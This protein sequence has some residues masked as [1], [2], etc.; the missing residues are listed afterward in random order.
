MNANPQVLKALAVT[1]QI[2]GKELSAEA[3]EV[4]ALDLAEFPSDPVL[5]S[6]GRCRRELR[7]FPT[8]ADIVARIEDGHPG[9]EEAWAMIPKSEDASVVWTQEMAS[10][11]GVVR[12]MIDDDHVAARV[13]FKESYVELVRKAR[14][15]KQP[16]HWMAS[17]GHD[18]TSRDGALVEAVAKGRLTH[19][20]A[21]QLRPSL[22]LT[23][24]PQT[25]RLGG[26]RAL[27]EIIA[28]I[29]DKSLREPEEPT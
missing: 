11:F 2:Y 20:V 4:L 17:M 28:A 5:A 9:P 12:H 6:L 29:T 26:P 15:R 21:L 18:P 25:P 14:E 10:A 7:T 16:I 19:E 8:V 23:Q 1:A 24:H 3:A 13:A 27:S 22:Q